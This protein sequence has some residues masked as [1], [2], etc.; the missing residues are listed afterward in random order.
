MFSRVPSSCSATVLNHK[1]FQVSL[2]WHLCHELVDKGADS[3]GSA[4]DVFEVTRR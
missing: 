2:E 4:G 3:E 1:I